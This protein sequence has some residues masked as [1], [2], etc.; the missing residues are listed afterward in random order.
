MQLAPTIPVQSPARLRHLP[1]SPSVIDSA[2]IP[3]YDITKISSV[4][5]N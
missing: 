5:D 4:F 1:L 2:S 3:D